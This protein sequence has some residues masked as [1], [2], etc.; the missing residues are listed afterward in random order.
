MF[1]VVGEKLIVKPLEIE[2]TESGIIIPDSAKKNPFIGT[3]VAIGNK[4]PEE[5]RGITVGSRVWW[6]PSAG[7]YFE[8]EDKGFMMIN[9]E[10]I[11][12][13]E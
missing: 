11:I 2:Q 8:Y 3:V 6:I 9:P 13:Y 10:H 5:Y 12:G 1:T 4:I 7:S